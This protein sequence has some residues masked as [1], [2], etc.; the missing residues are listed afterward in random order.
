MQRVDKTGDVEMKKLEVQMN[1]IDFKKN[2]FQLE[3]D[4]ID[5]MTK[6]EYI[7]RRKRAVKKKI[8]FL[9]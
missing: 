5:L 6:I 7:N 8:E 9:K 2:N 4:C 3:N 1:F